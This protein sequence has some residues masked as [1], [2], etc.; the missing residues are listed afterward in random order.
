MPQRISRPE[1]TA[2]VAPV[3]TIR[4]WVRTA[5]E[6]QFGVGRWLVPHLEFSVGRRHCPCSLRLEPPRLFVRFVRDRSNRRRILWT[7]RA[8]A[9]GKHDVFNSVRSDCPQSRPT[10]LY[11]TVPRHIMCRRWPAESGRVAIDGIRCIDR[12]SIEP[13]ELYFDKFTAVPLVSAVLSTPFCA[14]PILL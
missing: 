2:S 13:I 7:R 9:T 12:R 14:L 8:N 11:I 10:S 4:H 6:R 5:I 3:V 1:A